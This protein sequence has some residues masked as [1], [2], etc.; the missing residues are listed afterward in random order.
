MIARRLFALLLIFLTPAMANAAARSL[1][2]FDASG[3]MWAQ[4]DGKTRIEIARETLATVL[5]TVP[6]D[7][8][9]GLMVYGHRDKGSC[10]DIELAVPPATGTAQAIADFVKGV[11]PKGKTPI[12]ASVQQ[13]AEALRY[14]EDKATVI[15][16]TDGLETCDADPC[17]LAAD[18]ENKGVDFTAHVVGFGLSE[19]EG[20]KVACVAENT[21]GRYVQAS[22]AGQLEGA[23]AETVVAPPAPEPA[24]KP[25]EPKALD[26]NVEV[27]S[28]LTVGKPI[29]ADNQEV[30]WEFFRMDEAG[31]KAIQPLEYKYGAAAK[32]KLAPDRYMA[33]AR[34]GK[35]DREFPIV[36]DETKL[37][38]LEAVFDAGRV[39]LVPVFVAGGPETGDIAFVGGKFGGLEE[40]SYSR[41][42]FYA[43]AGRVDFFGQIGKAETTGTIDLKAGEDIEHVLVIPAG[44]IVPKADYAEGGPPVEGDGVFIE[45]LGKSDIAG[46]RPSLAYTYGAGHDLWVP[47]GEHL[48]RAS[49]D[50]AVAEMPVKVAAGERA[51][52]LVVLNA[53]V[54]FVSA[55]GAH[56]IVINRASTD[57]NDVQT[58]V[59]DNYGAELS[60]TLH[61][62]DYEVT[63]DYDSS[64]TEKKQKATVKAGERSEI[65]VE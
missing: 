57:I 16:V 34:L 44:L 61:P 30:F 18:L 2:V 33:H 59:T 15:L 6:A 65:K 42:T 60:A 53:G 20:R 17:A 41:F 43:A 28:F 32:F 40:S 27:Q 23:L 26:F 5:K 52:P 7:M 39:T 49:L 45:I 29:P 11:N 4:I 14:T 9:L 50:K 10:A 22:D 47:A 19:E 38:K 35:I 24:P 37:I 56:R 54:L 46:N 21:G 36:V 63:V 62:G 8:E 55:P 64:L 12:T 25:Q 58:Y 1:I 3:S 13:A 31:N 51:E 48:L